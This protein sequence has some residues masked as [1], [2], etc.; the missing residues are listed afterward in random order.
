M[1]RQWK[2]PIRGKEV[3]ITNGKYFV[4][5][6]AW[7]NEAEGERGFTEC[8]VYLIVE[9]KGHDKPRLTNLLK[10]YVDLNPKPK[11]PPKQYDEA[12]LDQHPKLIL[13][14]KQLCDKIAK[15]NPDELGV[16]V[17]YF[18]EMLTISMKQYKENDPYATV[19][20]RVEDTMEAESLE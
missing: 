14:M 16:Y 6:G 11:E 4:N 9:R 10:K 3:R 8:T 13:Q 17:L 18:H 12:V 19:W 1:P 5:E 20:K 2:E 15:H 7:I